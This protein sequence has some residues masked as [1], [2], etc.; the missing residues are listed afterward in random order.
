MLAPA[1]V[2]D[3]VHSP[4]ELASLLDLLNTTHRVEHEQLSLEQ[5]SLRP[6]GTLKTPTGE[7]RVTRQFLEGV[8]KAIDLPL[9]YG[10]RIRPE[11]FCENVAQRQ[12]D[13]AKP[14]TISRAGD[15]ATGLIVDKATR[16]RP[17][18]TAD[19]VQ[20]IQRAFDL[21]LRRASVSYEGVDVEFTLPGRVVEPI[22][23][24]VVEL[25]VAVSNSESGGRQLK[26]SAYSYRLVCTNGAVM[27][28]S[29]GLVRW[30]NDARMTY[31]GCLRA[32]EKEVAGLCE[33]L[34]P[35]ASL[36]K[37]AVE[38]PLYDHEFWNAWRRVAQHIPRAEADDVLGM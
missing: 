4:K 17:A 3:E 20:A 14:V 15:V 30:P 21:E 23:G 22:L 6:D 8:A 19:V 36:Y 34:E 33:T 35:M 28:D 7:L 11:L 29:L 27:A 24:D 31:A 26:A 5:I 9:A 10:Y 12:V 13:A 1:T 18:R 2:L 25:G 38:S 16:Y 37:S 32:F